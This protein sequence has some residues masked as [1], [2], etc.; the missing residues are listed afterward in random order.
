MNKRE[1]MIA[2][3]QEIEEAE[4]KVSL[5]IENL[6]TKEVLLSYDA[7][8]KLISASIIKVPIMLTALDMIQ[9]GDFMPSTLIDMP[10]STILEDSEVFE[11]GA[12]KYSLEELI[13]WMIINSD[14]SATNCLI[15]LLSMERINDYCKRMS[16]KHTKVER[17]MLDFEAVKQ[18][19]NNYTSASDM[20]IVYKSLYNK[21]M[22]TPELCDYGIHILKRQRHKQL[23]MRY[24]YDDVIVAHKTGG[25]DFI[26]HDAGIFYLE[27]TSY[28]FGA[29]VTQAPNN[30][31]AMRWIGRISKL[32][33]EYYRKQNK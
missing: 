15:D 4:A 31:Y 13:I 27:N 17:R 11:Y 14:N 1:L 26:N 29:F 23:S 20:E 22:L 16:L 9:S 6:D 33:Y 25:L 7:D 28:Y 12:G 10:K 8:S 18:G 30:D 5:M 32:V 24:L 19:F 21:S 2:I 3:E